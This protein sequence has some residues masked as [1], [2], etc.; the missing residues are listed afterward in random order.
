MAPFEDGR[1]GLDNPRDDAV[2]A[3][4]RAAQAIVL[5]LGGH[6][7]LAAIEGNDGVVA[8]GAVVLQRKTPA[9]NQFCLTELCMLNHS[10]C[11]NKL[12]NL[13]FR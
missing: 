9:K 12:V 2:L 3:N 7:R 10:A 5:Q 8:S 4:A 1:P 11:R 6:R 13:A